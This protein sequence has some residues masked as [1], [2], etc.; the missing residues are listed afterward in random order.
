MGMFCIF[1]EKGEQ[2]PLAHAVG[3][4]RTRLNTASWIVQTLSQAV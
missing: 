3:R 2:A 4:Q 1:Y